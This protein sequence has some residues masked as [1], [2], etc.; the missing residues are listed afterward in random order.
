MGVIEIVIII[1]A[2]LIVGL[3]I[4]VAIW[5]KATGRKSDCGCGGNCSGC[6][7]CGAKKPRSKS[8]RV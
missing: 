7:G 8:K 3:V 1:A 4:G 6:R 2:V 5:K